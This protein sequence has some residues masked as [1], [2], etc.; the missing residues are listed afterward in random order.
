MSKLLKRVPIWLCD[1]S[2]YGYYTV[3]NAMLTA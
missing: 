1:A 2:L 3:S